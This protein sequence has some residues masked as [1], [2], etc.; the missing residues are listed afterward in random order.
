MT[1]TYWVDEGVQ[2][3]SKAPSIYCKLCTKRAAHRDTQCCGFH[4]KFTDSELV[5]KRRPMKCI[6]SSVGPDD[7][8]VYNT[9]ELYGPH[10]KDYH[11]RQA[12]WLM[13]VQ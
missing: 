1:F 10:P 9:L 6:T 8:K 5:I 11:S 2:K 12:S 4:H 3:D 7:K 13:K